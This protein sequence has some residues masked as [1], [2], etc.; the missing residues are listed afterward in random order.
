VLNSVFLDHCRARR[1]DR[2]DRA[3]VENPAAARIAPRKRRWRRPDLRPPPR[4]LRSLQRLLEI[5]AIARRSTRCARKG[6]TSRTAARPHRRRRPQGLSDDLDEAM[7]TTSRSTSSTRSARGMKIVASCSAPAGCSC[8]R[9]AKRGDD[10]AAVPGWNAH[11]AAGGEQKGT[12]VLA[13]QGECTTSQEFG[14]HHPHQQRLPGGQPRIKVTW[15]HAGGGARAPGQAIGMSGLLVKSTSSC[16]RISKRWCARGR[17][18]GVAG[19]RALTRGYV[20]EDCVRAYGGGGGMPRR[21]D[22]LHLMDK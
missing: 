2:G 20:E 16:A 21:F 6:E 5:F 19:R 22:G 8:L 11:G 1:H 9:A 3:R 12:I 14:R 13:P 7:K 15:R 4:G 17:P 10:E 18:A